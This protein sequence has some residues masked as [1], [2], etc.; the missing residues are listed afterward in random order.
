MNMI[1]LYR[2]P[3]VAVLASLLCASAVRA[4]VIISPPNYTVTTPGA[5][6]EFDVNNLSSGNP[7]QDA[8][9][10][11]SLNF[12][13]NAGAT[14]ILT[15][16]TASFHPVDICTAPT[17]VSSDPTVAY[18]GASAQS[19]SSGT[20]TLTIPATNYPSTLYYICDIHQFYGIITVNPPQP[21]PPGQHSRHFGHDEHLINVLWRHEHDSTGSAIQFQPGQRPLA[22]GPKLHQHLFRQRHQHERSFSRLDS[23]CGP[24]VFLRISQA[25]N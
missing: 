9:V 19:T 15:M 3:A 2:R 25:T 12:S 18:S 4:Q 24:D 22:A 14:Y 5:E 1:C 17:P 20:V 21:P 10:N 16:N 11:D 23:I 6:F 13:L 7:A 8:N